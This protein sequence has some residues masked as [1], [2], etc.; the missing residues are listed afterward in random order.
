MTD[1]KPFRVSNDALGDSEELRSRFQQE[2]YLFFKKLQN[3]DKLRSLRIEMLGAIQHSG[4]FK[5]DFDIAEGRGDPSKACTEGEEAYTR[6]IHEIQKLREFHAAGHWHE[7]LSVLGDVVQAPILPHPSKIARLWFPQY[8]EHTTPFHQDFVHFQSNFEVISVWTPVGDCPI[9]LGPLAVIEGSHKV[10][11]VV[12][13]HFSL[14]AGNLKVDSLEKRGIMRCNDFEI[15]DTLFFGCLM[16]HGALPNLTDDLLRVSLDN[17]YQQLG[18]P[19]TEGQMQ[20]H[21]GDSN[22]TVGTLTWDKIYN[23]WPESD[24]LKHYWKKHKFKVNPSDRQF[25]ERAYEEDLQNASAG[26]K[27]AIENL[28]QRKK[29]LLNRRVDPDDS[30]GIAEERK[31]RLSQIENVLNPTNTE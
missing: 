3:P 23:S 13:H 10:N 31:L 22:P 25:G 30:A 2:G 15:G 4:W 24:D 19:V 21:L 14:G 18:L 9:E 7:V 11:K 12:D 5:N 29:G 26:N 20:P 17:R 6:T 28:E 1:I 8:T 27:V 16:V